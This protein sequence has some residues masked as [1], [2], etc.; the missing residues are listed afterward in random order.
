M[1]NMQGFYA[2]FY[3]NNPVATNANRFSSMCQNLLAD[4]AVTGCDPAHGREAI[5]EALTTT[6]END[7]YHQESNG[8]YA[9]MFLTGNFPNQ[10]AV[11]P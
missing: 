3:K 5:Q 7:R 10:M 9:L 2:T 1:E 4:G 6:I 8:V 11:P